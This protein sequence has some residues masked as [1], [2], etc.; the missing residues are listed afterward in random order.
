[1]FAGITPIRCEGGAQTSRGSRLQTPET[2]GGFSPH[3]RAL[4]RVLAPPQACQDFKGSS[5]LP[6]RTFG[7]AYFMRSNV[8]CKICQSLSPLNL[9]LAAVFSAASFAFF[10]GLVTL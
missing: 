4:G 2:W 8:F 6:V 1:M 9:A 5:L 10:V 3:R 7:P